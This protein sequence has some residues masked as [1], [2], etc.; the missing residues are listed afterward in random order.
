MESLKKEKGFTLIELL[1]VISV[2]GVL[3][4]VV[5][6]S[7]GQARQRAEEA[8]LR[9]T[10]NQLKT[11]FELYYLDNG[12]YPLNGGYTG[13]SNICNSSSDIIDE[14]APYINTETFSL[15]R[16]LFNNPNSCLNYRPALNNSL[17]GNSTTSP[18]QIYE[19]QFITKGGVQIDPFWRTSYN[20]GSIEIHCM[21][22]P[23]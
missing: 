2:I 1:V 5:L 15:N 8:K 13:Y 9:A 7:L 10:L 4:T 6:G 22:P 14:I 3:A 17:C 21:L 12:Q 23:K 18:G 19:I 20:G 16:S 11:G